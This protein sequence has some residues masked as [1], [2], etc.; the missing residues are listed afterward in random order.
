MRQDHFR[1]VAWEHWDDALGYLGCRDLLRVEVARLETGSQ[2][3]YRV[4]EQGAELLRETL[5]NDRNASI[6]AERCR[7]LRETLWQDPEIGP[8]LAEGG[9]EAGRILRRHFEEISGRVERFRRDEQISI[10]DDLLPRLFQRT[11]GELL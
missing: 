7:S 4:T 3:R 2:L 6:W 1:P 5:E 10:E 8:S 9:A 11:F